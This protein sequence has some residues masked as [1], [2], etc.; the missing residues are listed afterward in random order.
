MGISSF[1]YKLEICKLKITFHMG[2]SWS[3]EDQRIDHRGST[4]VD[5]SL[6]TKNSKHPDSCQSLRMSTVYL[7]CRYSLH[8]FDTLYQALHSL[9]DSGNYFP[10]DMHHNRNS[11]NTS[12]EGYPLEIQEPVNHSTFRFKTTFQELV[13]KEITFLEKPNLEHVN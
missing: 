12:F 8:F 6:H 5:F 11:S 10:Q 13:L 7:Y 1:T 3:H 4:G 9:V 2:Q